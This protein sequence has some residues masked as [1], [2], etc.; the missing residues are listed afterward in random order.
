MLPK[1]YHT[2]LGTTSRLLWILLCLGGAILTLVFM[3]PQYRKWRFSPTITSVDTTNYPIWNIHFPA[4]T[5]CSNNKVMEK[6]LKRE[7]KKTP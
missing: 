1:L 7:V 6:Q 4:V 2:Y 3:A 5:I